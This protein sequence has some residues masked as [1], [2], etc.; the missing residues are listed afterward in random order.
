MATSVYSSLLLQDY[1]RKLGDVEMLRR[2][3]K[4]LCRLILTKQKEADALKSILT[5]RLPDFESLEVQSIRT[6]PRVGGLRH[7]EMTKLILECLVSAEGGAVPK[8]T[9]VDWVVERSGLE[10]DRAQRVTM[11]VAVKKALQRL[12][13][14]GRAQSHHAAKEGRPGAWSL[15]QH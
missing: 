12:V 1:R 15:R 2:E 9:I 6:K 11:G 13:N 14:Q 3:L 7:S 5:T 4:E 8:N 10:V